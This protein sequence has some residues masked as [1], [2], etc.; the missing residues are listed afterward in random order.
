MPSSVCDL[1]VAGELLLE[2]LAQLA[3]IGA[4]PTGGVTRLAYSPEDVRAREL[5]AS[6]MAEA[7]LQVWVDAAANLF[8][9]LPGSDSDAAALVAGSHLDSVVRAGA[10]DGPAGVVSALAAAQAL[11]Q[12]GRQLRRDLIVA[13]FSNEEGARGTPGMVGSK[14]VTGL[15]TSGDMDHLDTEG[16]A[17][18]ERIR[19]AGGD[20]ARIDSAAWSPERIAAFS[21]CTSNRGRCST[22]RMSASGWSPVSP[23]RPR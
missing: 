22:L 18:S 21:N 23:A 10:L 19:D 12:S 6:W 11:Q 4:D 2:R 5:T 13:A 1:R 20:P 9:R 8:G 16:I 3:A 17:L 14:A 15:L 7:G